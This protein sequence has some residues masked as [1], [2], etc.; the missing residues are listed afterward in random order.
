MP[1]VTAEVDRA[2]EVVVTYLDAAGEPQQL[3]A[4]GLLAVCIQHELDHLIGTL[5]VDRL[6]RLERE[7]VLLE[8]AAVG[9]DEEPAAGDDAAGDETPSA[10]SSLRVV[11]MGTPDFAVPTL[12]TLYALG[13]QVVGV[14]SQ[15]D[16]PKGRG[17]K[18]Q[19]TPVAACARR[20]RTPLFQWAR[21]NNESYQTLSEL[22]PDVAVVVA[23]GKILPARYLSLP[24]HGCLNVHASILPAL[25]GAAPIQWAVINGHTE[26]G[27]AVMYMDE[28]MD[29]GD[30]A[31]MRRTPIGPD[32]TA[33]DLHDRLSILG[34][35]VLNDAVRRMVADTLPR[36]TQAHEEATYA[37]RLTKSLGE[38]DWGRD[39]QTIHNLV[40]GVSP[41]PGAYISRPDGPL[42]VHA[43]RVATGE[44]TP[45]TVL[46]HDPD[47]PRIACGE[48]ALTLTRL[49]RPGKRPVDGD[50]FLRGGG[51]ALGES[52]GAHE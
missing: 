10:L 20:H 9:R 41:W 15:P 7:A 32:E 8:Y 1:G 5:Y 43:A 30:V 14:V 24:T 33:G 47:G 17:R 18:L 28:G 42:K 2:A 16:R 40:R 44:G 46:G 27:V 48:G 3:A 34:A 37:P 19:H 51:L 6:G 11:F 49:Q 23:Y 21:L 29:T 45:G 13:C 38:I 4:D 26:T 12:E 36:T 50:D 35:E 39:A 31:L 52:V 22:A 25:R